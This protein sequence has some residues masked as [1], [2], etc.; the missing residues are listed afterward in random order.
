M[1]KVIGL[2]VVVVVVV[3]HRKPG[4]FKI[5]NSKRVVNVTKLSKLAKT[6]ISVLVAASHNP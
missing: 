1:S 4:Y 5:Y 6:D 2:S 3:V